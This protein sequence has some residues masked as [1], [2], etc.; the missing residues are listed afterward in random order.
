MFDERI[1]FSYSRKGAMIGGEDSLFSMAVKRANYPI[2]YQPHARAWHKIS[3][4]KLSKA[5]FLRRN[6]WEG[7]TTLVV[8]YLSDSIEPEDFPGVIR[9]HVSNVAS[10]LA[11]FLSPRRAPRIGSGDAKELMRLAA[12]CANS[13]G[14]IWYGL[15][16]LRTRRIP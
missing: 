16:F 3:A 11:G 1:G 10:N 15:R 2:Y 7:V 4:N 8:L 9:W 14:T 6:F 5:Y 12:T 13:L